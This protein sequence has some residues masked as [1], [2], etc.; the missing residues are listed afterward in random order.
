MTKL[1][2]LEGRCKV[3]FKWNWMMDYCKRC[4]IPPAE[5]WAWQRAEQ[6]FIDRNKSQNLLT[7]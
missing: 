3:A 2:Q 4:R 5:V 1:Q 7:K 6:A